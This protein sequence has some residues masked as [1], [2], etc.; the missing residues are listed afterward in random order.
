[1]TTQRRDILKYTLAA[2][3][4]SALPAAHAQAP[5]GASAGAAATGIDPR[6]RVF[7]TNEDS[8]TLVVIDPKTNT[9]ESTINL[10]SFDEDPRPPFRY[11]TAGRTAGCWPPAGAAPATFI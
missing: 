9:V 3:A 5:S 8:N 10:T 11:V 7:I 4:A 2:A 6:D 1:M